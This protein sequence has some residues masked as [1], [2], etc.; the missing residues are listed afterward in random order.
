M[1]SSNR[2]TFLTWF[3]C[4]SFRCSL[5]FTSRI[6]S[7]S[8]EAKAKH[9]SVFNILA[10]SGQYWTL[11]QSRLNHN[12]RPCKFHKRIRACTRCFINYLEIQGSGKMRW[13]SH[14][15]LQIWHSKLFHNPSDQHML[16]DRSMCVQHSILFVLLLTKM[17]I[18]S[19][20]RKI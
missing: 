10:D 11:G 16:I 19:L 4:E 14:H 9:T 8:P 5:N 3:S 12:Y 15:Y 13:I 18:M 7:K 1:C 20:G 6:L 17:W 2:I